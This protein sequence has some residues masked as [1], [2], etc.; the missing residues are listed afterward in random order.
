M[1]RVSLDRSRGAV[2]ERMGMQHELLAAA[3]VCARTWS[4]RGRGRVRLRDRL[5]VCVRVRVI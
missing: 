4:H 5:R 2:L 3:D 1:S